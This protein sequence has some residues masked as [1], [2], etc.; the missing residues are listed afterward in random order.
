VKVDV[1]KVRKCVECYR[2]ALKLIREIGEK[3]IELLQKNGD[4]IFPWGGSF[5]PIE[6]AQEG[7]LMRWHG[8][9]GVVIIDNEGNMTYHAYEEFEEERVEDER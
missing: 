3:V 6:M 8:R 7:E 2:T 4:D 1:E 5:M 9:N